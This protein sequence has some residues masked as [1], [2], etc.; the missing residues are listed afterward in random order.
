MSHKSGHPL[1]GYGMGD[2][3][4]DLLSAGES[5]LRAGGAAAASSALQAAMANPEIQAAAVN[6]ASNVAATGLAQQ[7]LA[8]KAALAASIAKN[9]TLYIAGGVAALGVLSFLYMRKKK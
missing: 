3:F 1:Q 8:Q 9:K 4:S 6:Q 7:I 2:M 5:S